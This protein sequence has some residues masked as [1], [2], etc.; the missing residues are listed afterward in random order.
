M[1]K[2]ALKPTQPKKHYPAFDPQKPVL[3]LTIN[4]QLFS[5]KNS[6]QIVKRG[7]TS[8]L[9]NSKSALEASEP[10]IKQLFSLK[11]IWDKKFKPHI[12]MPQH[13][14]FYLYRQTN[15]K[16]DYVNIVQQLLDCMVNCGYFPDDNVNYINPVFLGWEKDADNPRTEIKLIKSVQYDFVKSVDIN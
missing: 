3:T 12:T 5:K 16:F 13:I 9:I 11:P 14:G 1:P 10:L 8:F 7:D 6:K 15:R 4:G 2:K